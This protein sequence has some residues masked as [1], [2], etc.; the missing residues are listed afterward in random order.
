MLSLVKMKLG[1]RYDNVQA[2]NV[3][4]DSFMNRY[5]DEGQVNENVLLG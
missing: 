5:L 2:D 4:A 3:Y 1:H